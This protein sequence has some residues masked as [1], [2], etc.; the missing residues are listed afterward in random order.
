[1]S[2]VIELLE[3]L[4]RKLDKVLKAVNPP[5]PTVTSQ[6]QKGL[7]DSHILRLQPRLQ[8]TASALREAR[9]GTAEDIARITKRGRA[10]ESLY[11]NELVQIGLAVKERDG[12]ITLFSLAKL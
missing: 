3:S 7:T 12:R 6:A 8:P 9:K 11:L 4:D 5:K 1:M 10:I 2:R